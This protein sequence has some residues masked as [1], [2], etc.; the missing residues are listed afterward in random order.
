TGAPV[1]HSS[2]I[3]V[4]RLVDLVVRWEGEPYPPLTG[5]V[6]RVGRQLTWVSADKIGELE[7]RRIVLRSAK[8]DLREFARRD[9]EV[10]LVDDV[11]DHQM[12]D[13]DGVRVF[14]AAD[15][16]LARVGGGYRLV[17]A[18]VG[19]STLVRRLG[20]ARWRVRPHPDRVID[21]AAIQPFSDPGEPVRLSRANSELRRLRPGE[22]ADLLE[23]LGRSQRQELLA[24]LDA[25]TAAD[26]L[27]EMEPDE[28]AVLLRD[29]DPEQAA[30]LLAEMEPD[31]AAEALRDLDDETREE[32]LAVMDKE[33]AEVLVRLVGYDEETAGGLMTTA[34]FMFDA[35]LT[36]ADAR[37][38]LEEAED[39]ARLESVLVLD[40]D[41]TLL[42]DILMIDLF[43]ASPDD[44]LRSLIGSPWPVTVTVE[45]SIEDVIESFVENRGS[46]IVVVDEQSRPIGRILAD[47]VV[48]AL[49]PQ[50]E[51]NRRP[52]TRLLA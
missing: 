20:P 49:I 43:M 36:V 21:W 16:F 7:Q 45:A 9:N 22:L 25:E 12:V 28:L 31:E 40:G 8:V 15:L 33:D 51:S 50:H 4:G 41:G 5:L 42:D 34:L 19:F 46:S 18:D 26:A 13:V 23:E 48:D 2:G 14:R 37:Q 29:A 11:I 30:S 3:E 6:V 32:L 27:E 1:V 52:F 35:D 38:R 24:A 44:T 39:I 47:D 17:G 10:K